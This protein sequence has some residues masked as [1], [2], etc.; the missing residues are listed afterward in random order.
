VIGSQPASYVA[1][2]TTTEPV[3][4]RFE[5]DDRNVTGTVTS[6]Q[7]LAI[8]HNSVEDHDH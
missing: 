7:P 5:P 4:G 3:N 8:L 2:S 1:K 6:S